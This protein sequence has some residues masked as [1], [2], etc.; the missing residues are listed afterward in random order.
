MTMTAVR[1]TNAKD[2]PD[3]KV[4]SDDISVK[5]KADKVRLRLV[6]LDEEIRRI[7]RDALDS[8]RRIVCDLETIN[9]E[10]V[11][12]LAAL[13]EQDEQLDRVEQNL[14]KIQDDLNSVNREI[15][16]LQAF[17]GIPWKKYF[18]APFR[19]ILPQKKKG[20]KRKLSVYEEIQ[21][22]VAN[23]S[24][25]QKRQSV[26]EKVHGY[27]STRRTSSGD[28]LP[29]LTRDS[30]E[31]ELEKNLIHADQALESIRHMAI[32]INVQLKMQ[33]PKIDRISNMLDRNDSEVI[34]MNERVRKL[35]E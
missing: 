29:R 20:S 32:D 1:R 12:T 17:C 30:I 9:E 16:Y 28:F 13:D 21:Q 22:S 10:G 24:G 35:L 11:H 4:S 5:E 26:A 18:L 25:S 3:A 27:G 31:D 19:C 7:N 34:G 15:T 6:D 8:S 23:A 2:I 14:T 33:D